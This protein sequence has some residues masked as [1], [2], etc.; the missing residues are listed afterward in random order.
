MNP[1]FEAVEDDYLSRLDWLWEQRGRDSD[2][3]I[4]A[5]F[6]AFLPVLQGAIT[7]SEVSK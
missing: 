1:D 2:D 6:S 3:A 5:M 4:Y 7:D